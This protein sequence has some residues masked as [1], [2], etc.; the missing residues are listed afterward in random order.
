V[1]LVYIIFGIGIK[2]MPE[3]K[4]T[5]WVKE[6]IEQMKPLVEKKLIEMIFN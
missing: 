3:K 6:A 4:K 1:K 2:V 5:K